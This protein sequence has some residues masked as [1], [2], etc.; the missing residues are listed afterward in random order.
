M[1][2]SAHILTLIDYA[3]TLW[4]SASECNIQFI[5]RLHK[6]ALELVLLTSNSLTVTDYSQVKA[7]NLKSIL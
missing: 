7:L 1:I 2:F 5:F 4:D 3:S 6:R